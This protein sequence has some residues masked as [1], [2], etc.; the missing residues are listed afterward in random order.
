MKRVPL[1]DIGMN[2]I[3]MDCARFKKANTPFMEGAGDFQSGIVLLF[4]RVS[5]SDDE[6][7]DILSGKSGDKLYK[8]LNNTGFRIFEDFW[9]TSAVKCFS[10]S[11]PKP[12]HC[13]YCSTLLKEELK[14]IKPQGK[15]SPYATINEGRPKGIICFGS[16]ALRTLCP[17]AL[18]SYDANVLAGDVIPYKGMWVGVHHSLTMMMAKMHDQNYNAWF[19]R[20]LNS[21]LRKIDES[22]SVDSVPNPYDHVELITDY[23]HLKAFLR[24][25][26]RFKDPYAIDYETSGLNIHYPGH[27]IWSMAMSP[28]NVDT[29]YAFAI[30]HPHGWTKEQREELHNIMRH[31]FTKPR[32][33]VAHNLQ[34][35]KP[36]TRGIF[37]PNPDFQWCTMIGA[38]LEDTREGRTRLC[39][40][41]P[42]G[43]SDSN[44]AADSECT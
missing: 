29:S 30:D 42:N 20:T 3:C 38:H 22:K 26:Y 23:K 21:M 32:D 8:I 6:R 43:S 31:I 24:D 19:S 27:H 9:L 13:E 44:P 5:M 7:G 10:P 25:V 33:W 37:G 4:D 14:N 2:P 34:Y 11:K 17:G 15:F 16:D 12:K 36:W 41:C 28:L 39:E 1:I 40:G 35:E 18:S